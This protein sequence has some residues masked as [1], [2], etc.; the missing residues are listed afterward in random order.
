[1]T[2]KKMSGRFLRNLT[3]VI[4]VGFLIGATASGEEISGKVAEITGARVKIEFNSKMIPHTGD[5][6]DIGD[7]IAGTFFLVEGTWQV[8]EVAP[9]FIWAEPTSI[10]TGKPARGYIAII[11]SDVVIDNNEISDIQIDKNSA[12]PLLGDPVSDPA[13]SITWTTSDLG[14]NYVWFGADHKCRTLELNGSSKWKL[15]KI[16]EL[17]SLYESGRFDRLSIKLKGCCAWSSDFHQEHKTKLFGKK[18][19]DYAWAFNF[20]TGESVDIEW[21]KT[22]KGELAEHPGIHVLCVQSEGG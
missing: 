11:H 8:V 6:V 13:S 1:M 21:T 9:G 12:N 7:E 15:P 16:N 17:E 14:D 3:N 5:S 10:Y 20:D 2:G 19:T 22:K 4:I 18:Y